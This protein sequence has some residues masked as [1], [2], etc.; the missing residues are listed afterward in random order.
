MK[1]MLSWLRYDRAREPATPYDDWRAVLSGGPA[2]GAL[3]V[4]SALDPRRVR[5]CDA[6]L[7]GWFGDKGMLFPGFKV[8]ASDVVLDGRCADADVIDFCRSQGAAVR[9]A[10]GDER[11]FATRI[12]CLDEL[13]WAEAPHDLLATLA[14]AGCPG[15]HYLLAMPS[16]WYAQA[17]SELSAGAPAILGYDADHARTLIE[18]TGLIIVHHSGSGFFSALAEIIGQAEQGSTE[19]SI[20]VTAWAGC[21]AAALSGR[22]GA[23]IQATMNE[24]M[25][26]HHIFVAIKPGPG[27]QARPV[28]PPV[29][30]TWPRRWAVAEDPAIESVD[31]AQ[32]EEDA[33][34]RI[35]WRHLAG[36]YVVP[37]FP[38]GPNDTILDLGCGG[39]AMATFCSEL[40]AQV[41]VADIE[42]DNVELAKRSV[43]DRSGQIAVG[44]VTDA[45]PIPLSDTCATRIICTEVLEHVADPDVVMREL[46]RVGQPGALYLLTVPGTLAERTQQRLAPPVYF[47]HPNHIRIIDPETF[48]AMAENAGLAIERYG[49]DGFHH[50]INFVLIWQTC[51]PLNETHHLLKL[52]MRVWKLAISC[53]RGANL[54][55]TLDAVLPKRQVIIARKAKV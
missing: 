32:N 41:I 45:N 48:R 47:E 20:A 9:R 6:W 10:E 30:R 17:H 49:A 12:L 19:P 38:V 11:E 8:D 15:A 2:W 46:V 27:V 24:L 55:K 40:G 14:N 34:A 42:P 44:I 22:D 51:V 52:W 26:Q 54:Q 53:S 39:G 50:S 33:D 5:L 16:E 18:A 4:D 21:W 37:G 13:G 35:G 29:S 23:L 3:T 1:R 43:F 28:P 25:P 31:A 7:D 36:G